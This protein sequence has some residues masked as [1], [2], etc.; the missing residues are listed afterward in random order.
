M[1]LHL[2]TCLNCGAVQYPTRDVC[3]TCLSDRLEW[4]DTIVEGRVVAETSLH[5]SFDPERVQAGPLRIGMVATDL[6]IRVIA[7]LDGTL[8]VGTP[9]RLLPSDGPAG[10]ILAIASDQTSPNRGKGS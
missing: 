4:R 3:R 6:G 10:P 1:T 8:Q 7:S 2:Q 9:V 5:R